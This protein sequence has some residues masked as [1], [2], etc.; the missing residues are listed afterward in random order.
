MSN[1]GP[2]GN[3]QANLGP[4]P[5]NPT[6]TIGFINLVA[7]NPNSLSFISLPGSFA[8]DTVGLTLYST[9]DGVTWTAVSGGSG[10]GTTQV[11]SGNGNPNGVV[12]AT[13]PALFYA[14]DT[15]ILWEKLP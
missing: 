9:A 4:E 8:F 1:T 12:T 6:P 3:Y 10:P 13:E 14:K 7:G 5:P 11:F 2:F 15:G